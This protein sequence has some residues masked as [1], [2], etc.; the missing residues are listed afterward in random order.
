MKVR[1]LFT[2]GAMLAGVTFQTVAADWYV[3]FSTG[4][5]KN[6]GTQE[7]PLKNIWKAL[8]SAAP[9]DTIHIAEGN[10]SGKNVL[11]LDQYG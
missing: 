1:Q 4:K 10:Y 5:N 6:A 3:S 11:W 7:A 9:G 2:A 8:E